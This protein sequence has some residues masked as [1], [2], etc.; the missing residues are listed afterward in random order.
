MPPSPWRG[1]GLGRIVK[2][3]VAEAVLSS[4]CSLNPRSWPRPWT[5]G[6]GNMAMKASWIAPNSWFNCMAM[7]PPESS[8]GRTLLE[9]LQRHEDDAGMD[10]LVK[11]FID[12]PGKAMAVFDARVLEGDLAHAPDDVFRAIE[13]RASGSCAKPMRYCLSCA[14]T[15]PPGTARKTRG[16]PRRTT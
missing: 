8:G 1:P 15:K 13:R 4:I 9:R 11:P 6:G 5:G 3:P 10:E 2:R 16:D 14:G 12:R 7:A